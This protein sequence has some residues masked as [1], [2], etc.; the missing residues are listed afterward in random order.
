MKHSL[1]VRCICKLIMHQ[2][3]QTVIFVNANKF[4]FR[5]RCKRRSSYRVSGQN[6]LNKVNRKKS[7]HIDQYDNV[8]SYNESITN[9]VN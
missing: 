6:Q 3:R 7:L 8:S 9:L 2:F 4:I 1:R 5:I